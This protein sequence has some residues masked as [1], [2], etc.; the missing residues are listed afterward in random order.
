MHE[1]PGLEAAA[2]LSIV[3]SFVESSE[4]LELS[5]TMLSTEEFLA[6]LVFGR[7]RTTEVCGGGAGHD[8]I[9]GLESNLKGIKKILI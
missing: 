5:W 4:R 7:G 1:K 9:S 3:K 2:I 6:G 8:M